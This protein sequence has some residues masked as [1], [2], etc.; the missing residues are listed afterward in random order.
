M[1]AP[2]PPITTT[3]PPAH[4]HAHTV[5]YS[6]PRTMHHAWTVPVSRAGAEPDLAALEL[7]PPLPGLTLT[8]LTPNS[9]PSRGAK[10]NPET[11]PNP[12]PSFK[13]NPVIP[14]L[15]PPPASP[16]PNQP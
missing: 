8:W 11:N 5:L 3:N 1:P 14:T 9:D 4:P 7:Q 16:K 2:A 12:H 15:T 6:P 13:P 10:A